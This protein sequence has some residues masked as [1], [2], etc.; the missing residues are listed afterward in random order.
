M[1]EPREPQLVCIR[2]LMTSAEIAFVHSTLQDSGVVYH[3]ENENYFQWGGGTPV[4]SDMNARLMV[5]AEMEQA[6]RKLLEGRF[7]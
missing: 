4:G 6:A 3:I 2:E 5:E 7:W 1:S